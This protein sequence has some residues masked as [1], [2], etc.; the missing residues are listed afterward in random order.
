ML[1]QSMSLDVLYF[2]VVIE[3]LSSENFLRD[4]TS[5]HGI[6]YLFLGIKSISVYLTTVWRKP[7]IKTSH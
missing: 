4:A 5:A 2:K 3:S 7:F 6:K 1:A